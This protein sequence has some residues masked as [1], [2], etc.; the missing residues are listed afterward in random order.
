MGSRFSTRAQV[1][2][3]LSLSLLFGAALNI[4]ISATLLRRVLDVKARHD[5][6]AAT[7]AVARC[8][9]TDCEGKDS[10]CVVARAQALSSP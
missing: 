10:T 1:A 7:E 5:L 3:A 9:A 6:S 4:L 8:V 2:L